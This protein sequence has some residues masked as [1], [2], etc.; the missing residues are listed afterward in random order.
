M[1]GSARSGCDWAG[2][3]DGSITIASAPA[4]ALLHGRD[5]GPRPDLPGVSGSV[6]GAVE[7]PVL[8]RVSRA[9][10]VDASERDPR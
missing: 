8:A 10:V 7:G 2:D 1:R 3:S 5:D 9:A 6:Q 4:V